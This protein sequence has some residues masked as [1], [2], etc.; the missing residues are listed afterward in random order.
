MCGSCR[1]SRPGGR[2]LPAHLAFSATALAGH[3]ARAAH[4][5]LPLP[6]ARAHGVAVSP[7]RRQAHRVT[8]PGNDGR[9]AGRLLDDLDERRGHV[10]SPTPAFEPG[11][12][13]A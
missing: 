3:A 13:R 9:L 2:L 1:L 11:L 4:K 7:G 5:L 6:T 10:G 12:D 8:G